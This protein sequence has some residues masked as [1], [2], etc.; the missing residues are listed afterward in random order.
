[1]LKAQ[2][3]GADVFYSNLHWTA[4]IKAIRDLKVSYTP[5]PK[6]PE[7]KRDLA[8]MLDKEVKFS[9]IKELAFK[10][11]RQI[12]RSVNIFD[13]YEGDKLPEGKKSYAVSFILRDDE[14]TLNDKQIE[15]V[16]AKLINVYT[17]E[18]GAIIR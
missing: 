15:K 11:E 5:L 8:L 7:V 14:K 3:I 17:R 16:M 18:L 13:V 4:I 9:T 1:M 2:D 6:Y 12:L 10:T